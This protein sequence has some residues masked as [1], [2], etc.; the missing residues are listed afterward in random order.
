MP[1][2]DKNTNRWTSAVV[3]FICMVICLTVVFIGILIYFLNYKRRHTND[4]DDVEEQKAFIKKIHGQAMDCR[5]NSTD[6]VNE[7]YIGGENIPGESNTDEKTEFGNASCTLDADSYTENELR[8]VLLGT[9]GAGKSAIGNSILGKKAF[10]SSMSSATGAST[11]YQSH[12]T[13]VRQK[14]VIVD[15]P[16]I[17]DTNRTKNQINEVIQRSIGISAPG[18]HVFIFVLSSLRF[19]QEEQQFVENFIEQFGEQVYEYSIVLFTKGDDLEDENKS[20][21]DLLKQAPEN[22]QNFI[23]KC[24]GRTLVFNNNLKGE[25]NDKQVQCLLNFVSENVRKN[26]G[27]YYTN[28]MFIEEETHI[29]NLEAQR[30][31][32][33]REK[34][35]QENKK[36]KDE[37]EQ[38][39][40]EDIEAGDEKLKEVQSELDQMHIQ[41]KKERNK[42]VPC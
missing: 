16:G 20:L 6:K 35:E 8:L 11:Y 41:L 27:K 13:R 19:T 33:K 14:I 21:I 18:P 24:G 12:N 28:E 25:E 31:Q 2:T 32:I 39:Y 38:K 7:S 40:L 34:T 15:T 36:I 4:N 1:S 10:V 5:F 29:R 23:K 9:T 17:S 22:L 30:K 26:D 42:N 3:A 37:K